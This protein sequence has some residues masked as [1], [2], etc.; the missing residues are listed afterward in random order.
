MNTDPSLIE[1]TIRDLLVVRKSLEHRRHKLTAQLDQ[2]DARIASWQRQLHADDRKQEEET[3][4]KRQR[5]SKT[6]CRRLV[7]A[8]FEKPTAA[9]GMSIRQVANE[10]GLPWTTTRSVLRRL[11][12]VEERDGLWRKK[13]PG[14]RTKMAL[15]P[16]AVDTGK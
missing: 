15:E 7:E 9:S 2:L 6:E 11:S 12:T 8:V 13:V 4:G 10:S 3:G 14:S 16:H 1:A 5:R